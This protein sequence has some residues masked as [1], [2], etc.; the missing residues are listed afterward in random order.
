M[1]KTPEELE[2]MATD[3]GGIALWGCQPG[4]PS[5]RAGLGYGDILIRIDGKRVRSVEDYS[6][7]SR[8]PKRFMQVEFIRNGQV[9]RVMMDNEPAPDDGELTPVVMAACASL[10]AAPVM[11]RGAMPE[12]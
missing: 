2:L 9:K 1:R 12:A 8:A 5:A 3:V 10:A 6:S 11:T 7:A 4:S